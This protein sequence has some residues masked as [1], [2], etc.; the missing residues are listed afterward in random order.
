MN[1]TQ[2]RSFRNIRRIFQW[3]FCR[4]LF[5]A[6][7]ADGLSRKMLCSLHMAPSAFGAFVTWET[8]RADTIATSITYP[9]GPV[10]WELSSTTHTWYKHKRK[11]I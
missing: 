11:M 3:H 2:W 5:P 9:P 1:K 4:N 7:I 8:R 6:Q 10:L